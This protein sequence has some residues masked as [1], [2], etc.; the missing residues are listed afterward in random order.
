MAD[1]GFVPPV[2]AVDG[3]WALAFDRE[4][5]DLLTRLM[6][7]LRELLEQDESSALLDRLF[8]T[9]YPDDEEKEAEYQRLM[10]EELVT[11]RVAAID[12]VVAVVEPDEPPVMDEGQTI[13][14]MQSV[15]AI[16]LV[17]G[18]MLGIT[19][20]AAAEDADLA[21]TAE[22]H[23]YSYLGWVLEW[24]VRALSP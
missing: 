19:D 6:G 3:G 4:E 24:T 5:R 2:R 1:R 10:R 15:N 23:L 16:R 21:D 20:D 7:E 14:F 18:S 8:P 12:A 22:H 11:S 13:A 17:L 9:A